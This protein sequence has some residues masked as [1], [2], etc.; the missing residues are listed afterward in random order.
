M[1]C[2]LSWRNARNCLSREQTQDDLC[3]PCAVCQRSITAQFVRPFVEPAAFSVRVDEKD[4]AARYRRSTLVRQ[5]QTLTH[6]ID[7]VEESSLQ[8]QGLFQLALKGT[9]T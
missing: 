3:K 4:G 6:F 5:R 8:D 1:N 9:G 2:R 7:H